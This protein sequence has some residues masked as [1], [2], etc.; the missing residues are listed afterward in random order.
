MPGTGNILSG[1]SRQLQYLHAISVS[2]VWWSVSDSTAFIIKLLLTLATFCMKW[3]INSKACFH[4]IQWNGQKIH[5]KYFWIFL[6]KYLCIICHDTWPTPPQTISVWHV[7]RSHPWHCHH[8]MMIHR[9]MGTNGWSTHNHLHKV[10]SHHSKSLSEVEIQ[11][12]ILWYN[13]TKMRPVADIWNI[14]GG[15]LDGSGSRL[16]WIWCKVEKLSVQCVIISLQ[17]CFF[18]S[19]SEER[20]HFLPSCFEILQE[21]CLNNTEL[22]FQWR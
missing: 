4:H 14:W 10:H 16:I 18:T 5:P 9:M 21:N 11:F 1:V 17:L 6:W 15:G 12:L 22:N 20:E 3:F 8:V 2:M 13:I 19:I 7:H